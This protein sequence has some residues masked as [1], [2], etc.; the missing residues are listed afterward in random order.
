MKFK[1]CPYIA[2]WYCNIF[3]TSI[4]KSNYNYLKVLCSKKN[5]NLHF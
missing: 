5:Y 4:S 1:I 3:Y 2:K